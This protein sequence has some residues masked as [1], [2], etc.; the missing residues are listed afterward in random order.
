MPRRG[1]KILF[2]MDG[3]SELDGKLFELAS[4][5]RRVVQ[6]VIERR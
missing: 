1:E 2:R 4:I 5:K 6:S 3:A